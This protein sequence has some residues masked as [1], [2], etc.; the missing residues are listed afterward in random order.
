MQAIR[1]FC[2]VCS[3]RSAAA[4]AAAAAATNEAAT[5]FADDQMNVVNHGIKTGRVGQQTL[6]RPTLEMRKPSSLLNV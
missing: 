1:P 4:A 3:R 5:Q 6:T 2:T